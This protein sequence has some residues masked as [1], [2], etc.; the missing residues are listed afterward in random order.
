MNAMKSEL[1]KF[2]SVAEGMRV[3][4]RNVT[5]LNRRGK[6]CTVSEIWVKKEA[7]KRCAVN[8]IITYIN[9]LHAYG[10]VSMRCFLCELVRIP[11]PVI[12]LYLCS[13]L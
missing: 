12:R 1:H 13:F 2:S 4:E 8:V 3:I 10:K 11:F 5:L 9:V 7:V 6:Y